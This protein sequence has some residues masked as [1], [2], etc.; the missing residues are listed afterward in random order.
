[1]NELMKGLAVLGASMRGA[2]FSDDEL[3]ELDGLQHPTP[4]SENLQKKL[5]FLLP[6]YSCQ[7]LPKADPWLDMKWPNDRAQPTPPKSSPTPPVDSSKAGTLEEWSWLDNLDEVSGGQLRGKLS[8]EESLMLVREPF[9][10]WPQSLRDKVMPYLGVDLDE[11]EEFEAEFDEPIAEAIKESTMGYD[12]NTKPPRPWFAG[13]VFVN[14]ARK[15]TKEAL[16]AQLPSEL[17]GF[18]EAEISLIRAMRTAVGLVPDNG[19]SNNQMIEDV[20]SLVPKNASDQLRRYLTRDQIVSL[21]GTGQ[22]GVPNYTLR[23]NDGRHA[24]FTSP[25]ET[26][27]ELTDEYRDEQKRRIRRLENIAEDVFCHV[28]LTLKRD[29][30][31]YYADDNLESETD[32]EEF[33]EAWKTY[34]CFGNEK[35]MRKAFDEGDMKHPAWAKLLSQR[36]E[37]I[38]DS[39]RDDHRSYFAGEADERDAIYH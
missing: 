27:T 19:K 17:L 8:S 6:K 38:L 7:V 20:L 22:Y 10:Q 37:D 23:H 25:D 39:F 11:D 31:L 34:G 15:V 16:N 4:A 14:H 24:K 36:Q 26:L 13:F 32:F 9:V 30:L 5:G 35:D 1:M 33:R 2:D 3:R 29:E 12:P 21:G 18:F 28:Y